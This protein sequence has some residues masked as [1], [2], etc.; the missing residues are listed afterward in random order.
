MAAELLYGRVDADDRLVIPE[1]A[2]LAPGSAPENGVWLF[3]GKV[4]LDR[5]GPGRLGIRFG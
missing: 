4:P 5:T 1:I 2:E 3:E